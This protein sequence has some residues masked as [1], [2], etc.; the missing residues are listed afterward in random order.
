[1]QSLV[2]GEIDGPLM[3]PL[4][5]RLTGATIGMDALGVLGSAEPDLGARERP[6]GSHWCV[7]VR[8]GGCTGMS[9]YYAF[10]LFR[11]SALLSNIR[12]AGRY[13]VSQLSREAA[14]ELGGGFC[15]SNADVSTVV[16][17]GSGRF[18]SSGYPAS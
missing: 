14:V 1:V 9:C 15:T 2:A 7:L 10:A 11:C 18:T 8:T 13:V 6:G 17:S 4:E 3:S 16:F 5:P 12:G